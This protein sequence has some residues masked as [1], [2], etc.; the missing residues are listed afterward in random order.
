MYRMLRVLECDYKPAKSVS[1][2]K[3]LSDKI[4]N[5]NKST[6]INTH[7][8]MRTGEECSPP[9]GL[10][11]FS[12][13]TLD[14]GQMKVADGEITRLFNQT[15]VL[16][17]LSANVRGH[18]FIALF[19]QKRG[20]PIVSLRDMMQR[21]KPHTPTLVEILESSYIP[22]M[23][24]VMQISEND[25]REASAEVIRYWPHTG[26]LGSHIDNVIRTKGVM[27]PICSIN[28]VTDRSIDLLPTFVPSARPAR[29]DTQRG[30]LLV[31]ESDAR[32]LWSH[33]VPFGDNRYR[34][35]VIVR[36]VLK[37]ASRG[38]SRGKSPFGTA[39]PNP[40]F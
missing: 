24:K 18:E 31:M 39:I 12:P 6:V 26:G 33:S 1:S 10:G 20:E 22:L 2:A 27:G 23:A 36:P 28:L 13:D 34:F 3:S 17:S 9:V 19:W 40:A 32:I 30:D 8:T 38:K 14:K 11:V 5:L 37:A 29:L 35:S 7:M 21:L 25:V 15:Q 4:H 16:D